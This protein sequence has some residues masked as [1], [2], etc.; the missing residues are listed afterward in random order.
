M[1]ATINV[2]ASTFSIKSTNSSNCISATIS[3]E[4]LNSLN[5]LLDIKEE[6]ELENYFRNN[7]I[8][9]SRNNKKLPLESLTISPATNDEKVLIQ[10]NYKTGKVTSISN[11]VLFGINPDQQN[12]HVFN[13]INFTTTPTQPLHDLAQ[14]RNIPT[15]FSIGTIII[16][17]MLISLIVFKKRNPV[18]FDRVSY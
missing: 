14:K 15:S 9:T 4:E 5:H 6:S 2:W 16:V 8:L 1:S 13:N 11:T 12:T 7:I 17:F 3:V 10:L 18:I